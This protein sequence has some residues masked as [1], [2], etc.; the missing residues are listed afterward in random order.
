MAT[1][2]TQVEVNNIDIIDTYKKLMA[3]STGQGSIYLRA[4]ETLIDL[5]TKGQLSETDK[6][7]LI[8]KHITD[9]STGLSAQAMEM[10]FKIDK[11]NRDAAYVLTKLRE[12]TKLVTANIAKTE[13]D[14]ADVAS[15]AK[16][17]VY[18][19]WKTQAELYWD[20][21][22]TAYTLSTTQ[23]I[24]PE[25]AYNK[26]FGIKR[27]TISKAQADLYTTLSTNYR[28]NGSLEI[29]GTT[30][31]FPNSNLPV[32]LN[33]LQ[34]MIGV[35]PTAAEY[36]L[37]YEQTKV[38]ERQIQGF[39]DNM[40]QHVINS[41]ASM[42]SMLLATEEAE[43]ATTADAEILPVWMD[44]AQHLNGNPNWVPPTI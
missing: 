16:L 41:S 29:T 32:G 2:Y 27:Q 36:G 37:T 3:A 43:L 28:Q 22:I 4:K 33:I 20:C 8:S 11:E 5:V 17:K 30:S 38:A 26:E 39:D 42:I 18:S 25:L 7:A 24:I 19:G 15:N 9:L 1:E 10:A 40:R 13:A 14:T 6:A 21:G 44:A 31:M 35:E 23:D 34:N 12:D